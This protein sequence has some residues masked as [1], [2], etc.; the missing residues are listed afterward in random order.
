VGGVNVLLIGR[1]FVVVFPYKRYSLSVEGM[2]ALLFLEGK[3]LL[4]FFD[5]LFIERKAKMYKSVAGQFTA[6][7]GLNDFLC[8]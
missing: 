1:S 3:R 4:C 2:H 7:V 6:P 5:V 8:K